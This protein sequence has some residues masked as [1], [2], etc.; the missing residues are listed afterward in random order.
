MELILFMRLG[1]HP[2]HL[3]PAHPRQSIPI[4]QLL[5]NR[6]FPLLRKFLFENKCLQNMFQPLGRVSKL[7]RTCQKI[8]GTNDLI[9]RLALVACK[10]L[11][12]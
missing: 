4:W 7:R 9:Q 3:M 12:A 2:R 5:L 8:A 10:Y 6:V 1:L 11:Q